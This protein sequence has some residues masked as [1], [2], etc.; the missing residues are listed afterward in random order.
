LSQN[1]NEKVPTQFAIKTYVDNKFVENAT[2][3]NNV[4]ILGNLTVQGTETILNTETLTVEDKN[5]VLGNIANATDTTAQGGG[6]TLKGDTDKT[7]VYDNADER[8]VSNI[9]VNAPKLFADS[10]EVVNKNTITATLTVAGWAATAGN[11]P[12]TQVVTFTGMGTD[13]NPF[14]DIDTSGIAVADID[15]RLDDWAL[16]YRGDAGT[17]T[18]TFYAKEVPS[19]N[20]PIK[21][22]R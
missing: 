5:V 9:D 22:R 15:D 16:V 17:N 1:S 12:Y 8:W 11:A 3:D 4:E 10:V 21:I 14:V 6:I 13:D 18:V 19:A 2:F 7:L 20:I